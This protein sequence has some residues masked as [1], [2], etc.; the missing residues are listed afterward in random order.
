MEFVNV[1]DHILLSICIPTY[2]RGNMLEYCL[3]SIV[4]QDSFDR[5]TEVIILDNHSTD[6]TAEIAKK[7][8]IQNP[9]IFY[10]SNEEN[11]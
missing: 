11:I 3:E 7:F 4:R 5:R 1:Q 9:N 10:F 2:N 8:A 6:N